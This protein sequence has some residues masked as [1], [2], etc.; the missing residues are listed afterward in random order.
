MRIILVLLFTACAPGFAAGPESIL[1]NDFI[2]PL[3]DRPT[4]SCHASTIVETSNGTICAAW[5]GGKEEGSPDVGIWLSRL[6]GRTWSKP[7]LVADGQW[8]LARRWPCWNPV[9]YQIPAG[10]LALFF[11]VGPD[12]DAWWGEMEVSTDDGLSWH[13]RKTL[14]AGAIG[15]VKNKPVALADGSM[16]CPSSSEHNRWR[17]HFEIS[18]DQGQ[19]WQTVGPINDGIDDGAIQPAV[20]QHKDGRLQALC[21]AQRAGVILQTWSSDHGRSWSALQPTGLDNPNSGIDAVT[22]QDG[23]FALVYNPMKK[24]RNKLYVAVSRDGREWQDK[25][26]LEDQATGEFSYP[27]II[28][29]RDGL[30]HVTYT[31]RRETIKHA[32]LD[33]SVW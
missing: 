33:P 17:V 9:L 20:L 7:V 6:I 25:I 21:R 24:G 14:P 5:F 19:T 27:A 10:P 22:L 12:P 4:P 11:K 8:T 18:P 26:R 32:I 13:D 1:R 23:R 29:S 16:L 31:Y 2:Y 28:Q 3:N 30:I 15:P